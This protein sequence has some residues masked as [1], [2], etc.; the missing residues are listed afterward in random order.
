[1]AFLIGGANSAADTAYSVANSCRFNDGD[2]PSMSKSVG[3]NATLNT[4]ATFSTWFKP[5]SFS[6]VAF[7]ASKADDNN[8]LYI[9]ID[10][11][12][13]LLI[14][15]KSGGS[16]DCNVTSSMLFRDPSAWYN[17]VV[18][19]DTTQGTAA[20]RVKV[21]VNGKAISL[22]HTTSLT[23]DDALNIVSTNSYTNYIGAIWGT[24]LDFY[25]D[26]YMAE[27]VLI[28]GLALDQ[29]SFGE[30]NE[31]SPTIWQPIDV[32]GLTFGNNG[33]YLDYEDSANLGNDANGGTDFTESNLA[34]TDQASDSPTNSFCTWN[35]LDN[36]FAASTFS[37]GNLALTSGSSNE[38]YNTSTFGLTAGKWYAE[39]KHNGGSATPYRQ[40][41][42]I[43]QNPTDATGQYLGSDNDDSWGY[44]DNDG[45]VYHNNSDSVASYDTW[46]ANDII[47]LALDLDN[48]RLYFAKNG[49]WQ[50]SSDP[51]DGTNAISIDANYTY[52]IAWGDATSNTNNSIVNF[53]NP[54]YANSSD[55]ADAN[56]YGAFE[57]APPS[58]YLALCTKNLGSDGG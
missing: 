52:F 30:F 43:T 20:N 42:G 27:T 10:T 45:K 55:A 12:N 41:F 15:G 56:G 14:Y 46:T 6:E 54:P 40:L 48:N 17:L 34:A 38:T 31:D 21:Y 25:F 51:T 49:T 8:R 36:H 33:F 39:L 2:S 44:Y 9:T 4:K 13:N 19:F 1:M 26:G 53:G 58:G 7:F 29:D 28:D 22:T 50:G 35:P 47:G 23:E 32:S 3:G 18:A 24:G 5:S 11:G 16:A 57:Y 37:E